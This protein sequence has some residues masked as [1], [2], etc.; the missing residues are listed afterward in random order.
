MGHQPVHFGPGRGLPARGPEEHQ[1]EAC[2]GPAGGGRGLQWDGGQHLLSL[3]W[4]QPLFTH[5]TE[6][7]L[8]VAPL[9]NTAAL[10]DAL[11]LWMD[12]HMELISRALSHQAMYRNRL[13]IY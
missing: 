6:S 3:H 9:Y 8:Q 5:S 12:K 4:K 10:H 7:H 2:D 1:Q 13:M 11:V